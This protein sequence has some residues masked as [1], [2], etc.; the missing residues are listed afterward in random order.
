MA[1][2]QAQVETV[3]DTLDLYDAIYPANYENEKD[4]FFDAIDDDA[5]YNPQYTYD[6]PSMEQVDALLDAIT[7]DASTE[8]GERLVAGLRATKRLMTAIGTPEITP[9]SKKIYGEPDAATVQAAKAMYREPTDDDDPESIT[10]ETMQAAFERLFSALDMAYECRLI[11]AETNRN[12]PLTQEILIGENMAFSPT[13]AHRMLI[14]ESTHAVRTYNGMQTGEPALMYGTNGY[15]VAEEGLPTFNEEAVDVFSDTV[16]K[17]TSRVIAIAAADT[18]F[19]E[20][21]QLMREYGLGRRLAFIRTFRIKRG[22]AD[23]A[24]PGGFIKDHIYFEGY[25]RIDEHPE[26]ANELYIGKVSFDDITNLDPSYSPTITREQHIAAYN[27]AV[28]TMTVE[29]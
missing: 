2:S 24:R 18:G 28:R 17:I 21:Y 11:P 25:S 20:L 8:L 14:H 27:D 16:P 13:R 3:R 22:L 6:L 1:I 9:R 19:H 29:R 5:V 7:A 4:R 23:T 26:I 12:D 15:E 10:A